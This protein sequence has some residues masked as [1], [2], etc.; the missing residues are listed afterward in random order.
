MTQ[1]AW[2]QLYMKTLRAS[3]KTY[4]IFFVLV[5][6]LGS[7]YLVNLI[8]AVVAMAYE[9][10]NQ[11]TLQEAQQK[12][13]EFK[14]M[15]ESLKK[16]QEE[17]QAALEAISETEESED[18]DLDDLSVSSCALSNR[19]EKDKMNPGLAKEMQTRSSI[20]VS[21]AFSFRYPVRDGGSE[22]DF[23]DDEHSTFEDNDSRRDL[24]ISVAGRRDRLN[25]N[26]SQN[27]PS[28]RNGK[29]HSSVDCNG[30]V[31]LVSGSYARAEL[32]PEGTTTENKVNKRRRSSYESQWMDGQPDF[33][34]KGSK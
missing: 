21:S 29:M 2:E 5:I 6:F 4:M 30:V 16:Q 17:A 1:D 31:S 28:L 27:S 11:A 15:M 9:E 19:E 34:T 3:G 24:S 25:S 13:E 10:Q 20:H 22:N 26:L 14:K 12:A 18:G 8:L 33:S 32:L 23:A 7:F